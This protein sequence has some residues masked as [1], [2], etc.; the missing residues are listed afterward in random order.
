MCPFDKAIPLG[1][2]VTI[3]AKVSRVFNSSMEVYID[4]WIDNET[5]GKIKANEAI[6]TFVAVNKKGEPITIDKIKT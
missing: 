4:V 5:G 1:S 3:Q 2:T 6:Y